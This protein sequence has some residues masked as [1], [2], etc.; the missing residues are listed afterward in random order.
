MGLELNES[1]NIGQNNCP[2]REKDRKVGDVSSVAVYVPK[3]DENIRDV[4]S[5]TVHKLGASRNIAQ[6]NIHGITTEV[7]TSCN[8][9]Q[10]NIRGCMAEVDTSRK[11]EQGSIRSSIIERDATMDI[12]VHRKSY[13][14]ILKSRVNSMRSICDR[15]IKVSGEN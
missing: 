6:G 1:D 9:T 13:A 14:D 4:K 15:Q 3:E 10:G 12:P 7:G 2:V 5:V 8:P 11:A